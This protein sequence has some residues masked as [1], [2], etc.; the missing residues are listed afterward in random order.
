MPDRMTTDNMSVAEGRIA[1]ILEHP[2]ASSWLKDALRTGIRR[3]PI[4]LGN[5]LELL[6]ILL[7]NWTKAKIDVFMETSTE[8]PN[9]QY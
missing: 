1:F 7:H 2:A 5:D 9:C 8:S 3:D 6:Y 4:D